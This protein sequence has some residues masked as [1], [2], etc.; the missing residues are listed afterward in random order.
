[1]RLESMERSPWMSLFL[2]DYVFDGYASVT[3]EF[4]TSVGCRFLIADI[5][6]TLAPYEQEYPDKNNIE[7]LESLK[8]SGIRIALVSNNNQSRVDTFTQNL[9]IIAFADCHKP[10]P[11]FVKKAMEALGASE[12]ESFYLGDQIFT[13]T[14]AAKLAGIRSIKLPPIKDKKTLLFRVKRFLEIPIMKKYFRLAKKAGKTG[15]NGN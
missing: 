14:L 6:N 7:W 5:D 9:D 3:P 12:Q 11:S 10:R 15:I 8:K 13:D 4:L 1:M 2:P